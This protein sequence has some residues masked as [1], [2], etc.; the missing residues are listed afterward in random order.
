MTI[1]TMKD[2][3]IVAD[4]QALPHEY[5][6]IGQGGVFRSPTLVQT[7]LGSCVAVAM[8]CPKT[9][10]G[11]IFHALLPRAGQ[12][13]QHADRY[14]FVDTAICCLLAELKEAGARQRELEIKVFGGGSPLD[15]DRDTTAG[16]GNAETALEVLNTL[17]LKP[18]AV[19]VGG[20]VGRKLFFRTDTGE[21]LQKRFCIRQPAQKKGRP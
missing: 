18:T 9:M 1:G 2:A 15:V 8:H 10:L 3:P 4:A 12:Q 5:L 6:L 14:R 16:Q 20:N 21:V 7:V 19:S 17:G 11:G 13:V